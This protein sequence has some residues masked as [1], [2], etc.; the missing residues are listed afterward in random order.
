[1]QRSELGVFGPLV[2]SG[3][4]WTAPIPGSGDRLAWN[5]EGVVVVSNRIHA[6]IRQAVIGGFA[7][8]LAF[9]VLGRIGGPRAILP[10]LVVGAGAA[11]I[12]ARLATRWTLLG[13]GHNHPLAEQTLQQFLQR[14]EEA[15][16]R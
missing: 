13:D 2:R 16:A 14:Y 12:A 9:A 1:M 11:M 8:V 6:M 5:A 3:E 7:T 15:V 4:W 10:A